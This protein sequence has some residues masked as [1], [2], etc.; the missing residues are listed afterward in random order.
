[1]LL[2]GWSDRSRSQTTQTFYGKGFSTTTILSELH[3]VQFQELSP[4]KKTLITL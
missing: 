3:K 4:L 2:G 1:M